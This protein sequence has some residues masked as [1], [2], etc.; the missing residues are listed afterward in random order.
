[1]SEQRTDD[2]AAWPPFPGH[3]DAPPSTRI[4]ED[5]LLEIEGRSAAFGPMIYGRGTDPEVRGMFEMVK[6][7]SRL[8]AEIRRYRAMLLGLADVGAY[9]SDGLCFSC[10]EPNGTPEPE[11]VESFAAIEAEVE[12]IRAERPKAPKP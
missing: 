4:S 8:V 7:E 5:E 3:K 11:Q 6:R 9:D 10:G 12:A 2:V 1:M